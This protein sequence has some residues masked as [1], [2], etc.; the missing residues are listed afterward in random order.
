MVAD[1]FIYMDHAAT[2]PVNAEVLE[3]MLPYFTRNF[4]NPSS[5]YA[6]AQDAAKALDDAREQVAKV[7]NCRANEVIF[8]SGG[9]ESDNTALR[10]AA[11]ALQ[12][13]GNHIITQATEHHAV[14]HACESLEK[15]G[16]TV[17][18][19]GVDQYGMVSPE[20]VRNA[21]TDR[22]VLVSIM[23]ANNEIGT[24]Q[25]IP[26]I[27]AAVKAKAAEMGRNIVVHTD[28]VQAPGFLDLNVKRLG[29]DLL[30]LSSHKFYGP[31]GMGVLYV[32]RHT[33]FMAQQLGGSQERNR[34]AGTENVPGA[35]GTAVA[36]ARAEARR[37]GTVAHCTR[38]RD[39]LIEGLLK[40]PGTRLNGHPTQRLA[41]NVNVSFDRVEG[42]AV[43][44]N[45]DFA[46]VAASSGSA[47]SAASLEP[48]HVL[49]GI[50][51]APDL[52]QGSLRLTLGAENTEADAD[53]VLSLV[54]GLIA[55]LRSMAPHMAR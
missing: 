27:A 36:L 43:L 46:G 38:L 35:V 41:N 30:S 22:T 48:S 23:Y 14:I 16:F 20:Q 15:M 32:R 10:G 5:L 6:L 2:T 45:L 33:P 31:K 53:Y 7:L 17:T 39:R 11:Y 47:C 18:Y 21:V 1:K 12:H 49:V 50:G 52:A 42:E 28:A 24:V 8:T 19:L 54:P 29:V 55:R 51:L 25:P 4:G 37:A 26:E 13:T 40:I 34:R 3:A 9:T 44:L